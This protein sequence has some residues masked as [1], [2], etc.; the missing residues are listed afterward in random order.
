MPNRTFIGETIVRLV[1]VR[2]STLFKIFLKLLV[3]NFTRIKYFVAIIS[4]T[5]VPPVHLIRD[6]GFRQASAKSTK[7]FRDDA[8]AR[9]R[10]S[11]YIALDVTLQRGMRCKSAHDGIAGRKV[12]KA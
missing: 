8:R 5:N 4:S 2:S 9:A 7:L 1:R 10:I 6:S 12:R 3:S 11:F